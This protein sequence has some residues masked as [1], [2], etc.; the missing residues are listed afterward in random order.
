MTSPRNNHSLAYILL[1]VLAV[2]AGIAVFSGRHAP[3]NE[4]PELR[5]ERS[6]GPG[7][8]H[9][10]PENVTGTLDP[11]SASL[12]AKSVASRRQTPV[13]DVRRLIDDMTE[14]KGQVPPGHQKVNVHVLNQAL[15]ERWPIK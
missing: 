13:Q 4:S 1:A 2:M 7:Y 12:Q 3:Q 5:L 11:A 9:L 14:G 10:Y 15:D 8:F 6:R